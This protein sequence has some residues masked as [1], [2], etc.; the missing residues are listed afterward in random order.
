MEPSG[1]RPISTSITTEVRDGVLVVRLSGELDFVSAP[2]LRSTIAEVLR[3]IPEAR[4][5]ISM[6]MLT[7][8]D[9]AGLGALVAALNIIGAARGR[10]AL[11]EVDARLGRLLELTGLTQAFEIRSTIGD[12]MAYL[13]GDKD[14][15]G[16]PHT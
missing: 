14:R 16:D 13:T 6:R 5:L 9:S 4:V 12:A 8:C 7:F 11:C 15:S 1:K 3:L 2:S 10:L